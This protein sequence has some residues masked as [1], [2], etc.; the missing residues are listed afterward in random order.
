[1]DAVLLTLP[2]V[3]IVALL[4]AF[5]IG[6][7]KTGPPWLQRTAFRIRLAGKWLLYIACFILFV[8]LLPQILQEGAIWLFPQSKFGYRAKYNVSDDRV[9]IERK[10]Y[11]CEWETA[12]LGAKHCHYERTVHTE[13]DQHGNVTALYVSWQK[14]Q[15]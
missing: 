6:Q 15:D 4:V 3:V 14:V 9:I 5:Y 7:S 11:D 8:A 13:T 12:P 1:M 10:P 2:V